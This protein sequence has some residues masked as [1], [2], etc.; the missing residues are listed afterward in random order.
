MNEQPRAAIKDVAV[1]LPAR[2]LSNEDLTVGLDEFKC[3]LLLRLTGVR[4]RHVAAAEETALDLGEQACRKLFASHPSLAEQIDT[5]I[6]CTQSPDY[7]LPPN[8][9]LLHGRLGLP[10]SVAA[11]DLPHACSAYIYAIHV[12]QAL[13]FSGAAKNVLVVTADTYS[14]FLHAQDLA[15]RALFGDAGAASW[16]AAARDGCGVLDVMCGTDGKRFDKFMIPAGGCRQPLSDD[17]RRQ[18]QRDASGNVRSPANIQM[19]GNDILAFVSGRIPT[20][21]SALLRRNNLTLDAVD[22]I[23]FHQA[24]SVVLNTLTALLDADPDKV[25]WHLEDIGNTV[26]ASIPATLRAALDRSQIRSGQLLLLCGFG[27]GL[28]WGSALVRW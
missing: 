14:K 2:V 1:A 20:H 8:A 22:W 16:I 21:I 17:V 26:S 3:S 18:E 10:S 11:F 12:A 23:V 27:A 13:L 28:S 15:T 7:I 4:H 24:S 25:V 9:C 19:R 6:F 5:L